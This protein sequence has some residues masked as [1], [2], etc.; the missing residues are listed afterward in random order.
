MGKSTRAS[1]SSSASSSRGSTDTETEINSPSLPQ[2]TEA[3]ESF[4]QTLISS[5]SIRRSR[6]E[7]AK[8]PVL[9]KIFVQRPGSTYYQQTNTPLALFLAWLQ[10]ARSGLSPDP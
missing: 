10:L 3:E 2:S 1:A 7:K 6:P 5:S 8:T 9:W 4:C